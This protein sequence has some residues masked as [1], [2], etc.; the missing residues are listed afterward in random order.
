MQRKILITG[1]RGFIGSHCKHFFQNEGYAVFCIGH[2][3]ENNTYSLNGD[4]TVENLRSLKQEF[5]TIL[6]LAGSGTVSASQQNPDIAYS[7]SVASTEAILE[8]VKEY[9]PSAKLIY[10]SSAAVYGNLQQESIKEDCPLNPISIYGQHKLKCEKLCRT[11]HEK[12][13][14]K[15]NIIRFFSI[16]GIGLTKQLLWDFSG[17]I[18]KNFHNPSIA[19]YGT[20]N[21]LRDFLHITDAVY[22]IYLLDT[23]EHKFLIIN[24]GTAISTKVA[25]VC[26]IIKKE[27]GYKGGFVYDNIEREG[28]PKAIIAN[29]DL[30]SGLGFKPTVAIKNGVQDYVQWYKENN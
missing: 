27:L 18:R 3:E 23:S 19:C 4:I 11:Y 30:A 22:L 7:N 5:H 16:Y 26:H 29:I 12:H 21:E 8:Y 10:I 15:I 1:S 9:N 24:G 14:L 20:G 28:N 25:D 13:N 2:H 17:R 6:H